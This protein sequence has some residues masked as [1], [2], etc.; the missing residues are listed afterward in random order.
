[1]QQFPAYRMARDLAG[2]V[3]PVSET[4]ILQTARKYGIG[5]KMGRS[6]IFGPEDCKKLY[7]VLPC[8]LDSSV[9]QK[10]HTG[11]SAEP[12]ALYLHTRRSAAGARKSLSNDLK[13][14]G[15]RVRWITLAEA[16]RLIGT[17]AEHL[18]PLVT[19]L[20]YVGARCGE[21]LWLDWSHVDLNRGHV[22]FGKTKNS[23]ARGVPLHPRVCA[24][25]ANLPHRE[26]EGGTYANSV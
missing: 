4:V 3:F 23:E 5:R 22:I 9:D 21:A 17:C 20:L 7:E 2:C 6:I 13:L 18:R 15:D 26:G 24:A 12:S 16:E 10:H 14:P 11:S 8:P 1:M 19:F 25:L